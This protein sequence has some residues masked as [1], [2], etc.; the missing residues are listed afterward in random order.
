[1]KNVDETNLEL[2]PTK[3]AKEKKQKTKSKDLQKLK[4]NWEENPTSWSV[5]NADVRKEEHKLP[6][7]S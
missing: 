3:S 2:P 7:S 5:S 1:M 6:R 4:T